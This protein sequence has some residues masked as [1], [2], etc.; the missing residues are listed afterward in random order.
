MNELFRFA[1]QIYKGNRGYCQ[2][3]YLHFRNFF[4]L[5]FITKMVNLFVTILI[6]SLST[7]YAG[8]NIF[9]LLQTEL[10]VS[11]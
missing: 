6:C 1:L 9:K 3:F 5:A 2:S 7:S 10:P 11:F 4:C 8:K